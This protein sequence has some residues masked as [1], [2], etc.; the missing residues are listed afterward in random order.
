[1]EGAVHADD[2]HREVFEKDLKIHYFA[3]SMHGSHGWYELLL[4]FNEELMVL[5]FM[6]FCVWIGT[7]AE[8][9]DQFVPP[10]VFNANTPRTALEL[11]EIVE[12]VHMHLFIAMIFYFFSIAVVIYDTAHITHVM[13]NIQMMRSAYNYE[14]K[15]GKPFEGFP[16]MADIAPDYNPHA[17]DLAS[18]R[19]PGKFI[20]IL[21]TDE[22]TCKGWCLSLLQTLTWRITRYD[23]QDEVN[24]MRSC[25]IHQ[26]A[27]KMG[28]L[29]MESGGLV[30]FDFA[31]YC[32][33]VLEKMTEEVVEFST[34][35][36]L[37]ILAYDIVIG[38]LAQELP[39]GDNVE[40]VQLGVSLFLVLYF[41]PLR[42]WGGHKI[43]KMVRQF[44]VTAE[45][46]REFSD[47]GGGLS[48]ADR[49][50]TTMVDKKMDAIIERH[51]SVLPGYSESVGDINQDAPITKLVWLSWLYRTC[52]SALT[53]L[54]CYSLARIIGAVRFYD[55]SVQDSVF[56]QNWVLGLYA[57]SYFCNG[58]L[59]QPRALPWVTLLLACPPNLTQEDCERVEKVDQARKDQPFTAEDALLFLKCRG[60]EDLI[61]EHNDGPV[62]PGV[63][64]DKDGLEEK[65]AGDNQATKS[66]V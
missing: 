28:L 45:V 29:H 27:I 51:K 15:N 18:R 54:N 48:A 25:F 37:L 11:L 41:L 60:L 50:E 64:A 46:I 14:K 55:G 24:V 62:M 65:H 61:T 10:K 52:C 59:L 43:A 17:E 47:A 23:V 31:L 42:W 66:S 8:L 36:W 13:A 9:W 19:A 58:F 33:A 16:W 7:V 35:S 1:M 21:D 2:A 49:C 34:W 26:G 12:D 39:T 6:A 44:E 20:G 32:H 53:F 63:V 56:S 3:R 57:M 22:S 30:T 4:R 40:Y 5:G 38:V